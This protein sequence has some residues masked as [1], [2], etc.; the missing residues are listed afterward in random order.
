MLAASI[1]LI[2]E[3][4]ADTRDDL[5]GFTH[6][7]LFR[8]A[9]GLCFGVL[10]IWQSK[11]KIDEQ[12][13]FEM[14]DLNGLDAKKVALI[15]CVMTLHSLSEGIGIGVSYNSQ[16]LGSFISL[17]MAVHNIPEGIAIAIVMIPRGVTKTRSALWCVFSSFPQPVM[18]VPAYLFVEAFRPL[19]SVGLGF[20]AGAMSYVA[21]FELLQDASEVLSIGRALLATGLSAL[22]MVFL[23]LM[24]RDD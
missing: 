14:M 16:S 4:L 17:T 1:G 5:S 23:Q 13:S 24:I 11:N 8:V 18:S 12:Q 10:F 3:G 6:S 15:M 9:V 21:I 19:F 20:A 7:S 22:L 2:E